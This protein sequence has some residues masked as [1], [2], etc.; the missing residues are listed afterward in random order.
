VTPRFAAERESASREL[1]PWRRYSYHLAQLRA[2]LADLAAQLDVDPA[3]RILDY[4]SADSP[5]RSYFPPGA[6]FVPADLPGNPN[7]ALELTAEGAVPAPDESFD[8]V[9]STQVLEHVTDPGLHLS[10]A[11]RLLRPGGRLLLS[12]HGVFVWHPDPADYWRWTA[13]GLRTV[14]ERAGFTVTRFEGVVGLFP[15]A[16][17][18]AG[19]ALFWH[20]PRPLR[21]SLVAAVELLMRVTDRLHSDGGRRWNAQVF[22]LVAE[23]PLR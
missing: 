23:K 6:D 4:G 12:T 5:Y 15:T 18:L 3:A 9:L 21:P 19:D 1:R 8:V 22:A 7:A 10:E 2:R 13:E 14:T 16:V 17:Q 11:F 20:V